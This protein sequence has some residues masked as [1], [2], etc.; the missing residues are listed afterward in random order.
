LLACLTLHLLLQNEDRITQLIIKSQRIT[1]VVPKVADLQQLEFGYGSQQSSELIRSINPQLM[2]R[3]KATDT[4]RCRHFQAEADS[5][6]SPSTTELEDTDGRR[7]PSLSAGQSPAFAILFV[8]IGWKQMKT[9]QIDSSRSQT[10][11][12]TLQ[13]PEC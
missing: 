11:G 13:V 4:A 12:D 6:N 7:N 5:L 2:I 10:G 9:Q 8:G 1:Q 3:S